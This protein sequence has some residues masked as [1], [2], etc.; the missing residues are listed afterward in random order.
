[1]IEKLRE[2][3]HQLETELRF[4][5]H[6]YPIGIEPFPRTLVGQGFFPGGDG[7]WRDDSST[8]LR[9]ASPFDFPRNGIMFLGNDF[10]SLKGFS[11]LKLH[12]NPP[13][14]R[15]LRRRLTLAEVPG[16]FGFYTNA[17]L[18]LRSDRVALDKGIRHKDYEQ[19]CSEFLSFQISTQDPR[20]IVVLGDR[21]LSLLRQTFPPINSSSSSSNDIYRIKC[22]ASL[23]PILQVSHPYSDLGKSPIGIQREADLIRHAWSLASA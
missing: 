17:Y 13:T 18:G 16:Q 1:M 10:G 3:L 2:Q 4:D 11:K 7:L 12:E 14:W 19:L 22:N 23:I 8:A 6:S 15:N 21:P 20:L 9:Q 5:G